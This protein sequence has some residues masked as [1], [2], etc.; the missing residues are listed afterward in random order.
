MYRHAACRFVWELGV[1]NSHRNWIAS[2][3]IQVSEPSL[4][5][6]GHKTKSTCPRTTLHSVFFISV[7][8]ESVYSTGSLFKS[9]FFIQPVNLVHCS[10]SSQCKQKIL[11]THIEH[12]LSYSR[13][14]D[15]YTLIPKT[16]SS[17]S[18][19]FRRVKR[20]LVYSLL[21][22]NHAAQPNWRQRKFIER[23]R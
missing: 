4:D 11:Y 9:M 15:W 5:S 17:V 16:G 20:E 7:H 22:S 19:F 21:Q 1:Q 12:R 10:N 23:L 6:L 13:N 3:E 8:R 2:C 14:T 18:K